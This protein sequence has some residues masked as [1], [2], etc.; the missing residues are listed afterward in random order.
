[1]LKKQYKI[2]ESE[3]LTLDE[4][5]QIANIEANEFAYSYKNSEN[6]IKLLSNEN[7]KFILLK[8]EGKIIFYCI[9]VL[10]LDELEIYKI[11]V[12]KNERRMSLAFE[13][14]TSILFKKNVKQILAEVQ[15]ENIIGR[16]FYKKLGFEEIRIRKN[17]YYDNSNCVTLIKKMI[18]K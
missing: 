3:I 9:Y 8:K 5:N 1:M 16:S 6:I 13:V 18:D 7:H 12:D 10:L 2:I 15:E 11:W 14:V 4:E 17:Y